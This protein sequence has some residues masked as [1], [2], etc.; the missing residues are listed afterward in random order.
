MITVE[1]ENSMYDKFIENPYLTTKDL[2]SI[3]FT[4]RDLT[5]LKKKERLLQYVGV[6]M[7]WLM[8]MDYLNVLRS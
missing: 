7:N 8:Q 2:L 6:F 3:G 5:R 4:N 1:Y